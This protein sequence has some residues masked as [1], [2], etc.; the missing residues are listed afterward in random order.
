MN[1]EGQ[2]EKGGA[3]PVM[4]AVAASAPPLILRLFFSYLRAKRRANVAGKRF[5]EA[6]VE[7]GVPR[8]E[9][10]ELADEYSSSISLRRIIR[11][12]GF[13]GMAGRLMR[14]S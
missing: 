7:G 4:L 1:S 10:R 13:V 6:M 9:A 8:D 12:F 14:Q 2:S 11:D 5:F 3:G